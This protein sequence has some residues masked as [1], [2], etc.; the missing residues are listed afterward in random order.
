MFRRQFKALVEMLQEQLS[1]LRQTSSEQVNA[2]GNAEK[3]AHED[4]EKIERAVAAVQTPEADYTH[5]H[6][7]REKNY[8]VQVVLTVV[9]GLAFL[10]AATYAGLAWRQVRIMNKTYTEIQRQTKAAEESAYAACE[11]AQIARQSLIQM[12]NAQADTHGATV[13]AVEQA[14]A[15]TQS[16]AAHLFVVK[17]PE[18][19][20]LTPNL[21]AGEPIRFPYVIGNGGTTAALKIS[22]IWNVDFIA[23]DSDPEFFFTKTASL[24]SATQMGPHTRYPGPSDRNVSAV[25]RMRNGDIIK[26]DATS[27]ETYQAGTKD[28]VAYALS[29]IHI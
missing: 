18:K 20:F 11:D 23:R 22:V 28:I 10:A 21:T 1:T 12:E 7:Y 25:A 26:A 29:L 27:M 24:Y 13:A 15:V 8:T 9:T 16:G 4:R 5:A 2:I 3:T 14:F 19:E 6:E 17:N